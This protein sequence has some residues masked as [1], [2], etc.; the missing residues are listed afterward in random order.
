MI[1]KPKVVFLVTHWFVYYFV[2]DQF[3]RCSGYNLYF[4]MTCE[5]L[6]KILVRAFQSYRLICLR[7]WVQWLLLPSWNI[8]WPAYLQV[9]HITFT[10]CRWNSGH[11]NTPPIKKKARLENV[12]IWV[13]FDSQLQYCRPIQ[14]N[15]IAKDSVKRQPPEWETDH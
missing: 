6:L 14:Q 12:N 10:I 8:L 11:A 7:T 4:C 1:H 5:S 9:H 2:R 13:Y 15:D 3:S